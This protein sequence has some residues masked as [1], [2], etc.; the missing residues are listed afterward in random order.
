[1]Y[2]ETIIRMMKIV[3]LMKEG[4][5]FFVRSAQ[6][7]LTFAKL[8]TSYLHVNENQLRRPIKHA[9]DVRHNILEPSFIR[10]CCIRF[11]I[12]FFASTTL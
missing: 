7:F 8:W 5:V 2:S 3:R 9:C 6:S 1:M 11:T 10:H 12:L 4:Q